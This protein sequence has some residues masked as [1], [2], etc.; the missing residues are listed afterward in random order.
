MEPEH[1]LHFVFDEKIAVIALLPGT[2]ARPDGRVAQT[3][4]TREAMEWDDGAID[5]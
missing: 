5:P 4:I 2:M 1:S 3:A